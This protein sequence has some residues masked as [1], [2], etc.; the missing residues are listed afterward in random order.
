MALTES[1]M[2]PLGTK[3]PEFSLP[4]VVNGN[5]ESLDQLKGENGSVIVFMC[6]HCP[7]V[8]YLIDHFVSFAKEYQKKGINTIAISSNDVENYPADNPKLM[9]EL[10]LEKDFSF[11]YLYDEDQ[12]IA[13]SYD[14]ACTPD[15]FVL[16]AKDSLVYR[17]RYDRSRPGNPV[18]TNGEDLQQALDSMLKKHPISDKQYP[19]IGCN[20]KWKAGNEP[21]DFLFKIDQLNHKFKGCIWRDYPTSS[22]SSIS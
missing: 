5:T 6:N 14:A 17:G 11:S 2:L 13:K 18:S 1:K 15:F 8:V 3:A 12:S 22:S 21:T 7:Y 20:I 10:A 9:R 16:D 4:N 19:S